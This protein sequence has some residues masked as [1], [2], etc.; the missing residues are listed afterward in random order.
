INV[1]TS[2]LLTMLVPVLSAHFAKRDTAGF[3]RDFRQ[4]Y[5]FGLLIVT[6]LI[7]FFCSSSTELIGFIL[8]H[9]GQITQRAVAEMGALST[10]YAWSALVSFLYIIF[11]LALLATNK[12]KIYAF[13]G[14]LAQ[15]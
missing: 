1:L 3:L 7:A 6:A 2:V 9:K 5:Q 4:L 12:G 14:V 13:F 10:Y 11:G 15:L 8:Y